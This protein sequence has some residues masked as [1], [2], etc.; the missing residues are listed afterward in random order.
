MMVR[1]KSSTTSL[2]KER[3]TKR[4]REKATANQRLGNR[5]Q[6]FSRTCLFVGH[7]FLGSCLWDHFPAHLFS[8]GLLFLKIRRDKKS[9][10]ENNK[11]PKTQRRFAFALLFY[12][13]F[14][15]LWKEKK[16]KKGW[17]KETR[18]WKWKKKGRDPGY[19]LIISFA[20][21]FR[22]KERQGKEIIVT[23]ISS[24]IYFIRLYFQGQRKANGKI[25]WLSSFASFPL[26][27]LFPGKSLIAPE[28][29]Q[30]TRKRSENT[31]SIAFIFSW[32]SF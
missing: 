9:W 11:I 32:S 29:R 24:A 31:R 8:L 2:A 15:C 20:F 23:W 26:L 25:K 5:R 14:L 1:E 28:E 3:P 4:Q 12:P 19:V 7:L 27:T 18:L 22:D 16:R 30:E 17:A 10:P 21:I 6:P 13:P